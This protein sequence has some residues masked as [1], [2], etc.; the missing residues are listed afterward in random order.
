MFLWGAAC[1]YTQGPAVKHSPGTSTPWEQSR[2][3]WEEQGVFFFFFFAPPHCTCSCEMYSRVHSYW[4]H[5]TFS[6]SRRPV[7][8]QR[9]HSGLL[10]NGGVR[11]TE[12]RASGPGT[13]PLAAC[14][15]LGLRSVLSQMARIVLRVWEKGVW[16]FVLVVPS[17]RLIQLQT[18][19]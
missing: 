17:S 7:S 19:P 11:G 1:A 3:F 2:G 18:G 5:S 16:R 12:G 8:E 9:W 6:G 14:W 10:W 15:V 13:G 4:K